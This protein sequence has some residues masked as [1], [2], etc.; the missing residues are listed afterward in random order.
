[1]DSDDDPR[2]IYALVAREK[3]VLAECALQ[4]G[5]FRTIVNVVLDKVPK[6]D[7]KLS[8][9]YDQYCFHYAVEDGTTMLCMADEAY[10]RQ[11]P[12]KFLEDI[13]QRWKS[14]FGEKGKAP[15]PL[16]FNDDFSRTLKQQMEYY[17]SRDIDALNRVRKELESTKDIMVANIE[18]ITER[19][20]KIDLLVDQTQLLNEEAIQFKKGSTQLKRAMWWKDF[21]MTALLASFVFGMLFVFFLFTCGGFSCLKS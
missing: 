2:I 14:C 11:L 21:K 20:E 6:H 18:K 13:H 19:G 15:L 1:M 17:N 5:N 7:Y 9:A 16:Q 10:G 12:F 8:Y 3:K 4:S